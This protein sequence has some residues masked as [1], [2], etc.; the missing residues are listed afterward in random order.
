MFDPLHYRNVRRPAAAAE[1]LPSWCY[2]SQEFYDREIARI[3]RTSWNFIG[4][5]DEI[6]RPGDYA[7]FDLVGESIIV[8][9][10]AAGRLRAFANTCRHRGTRLLDGT[11]NCK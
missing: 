8:L 3:F 9:R 10:D 2:T 11:G 4:R 5:A 6:A 7:V 1:T